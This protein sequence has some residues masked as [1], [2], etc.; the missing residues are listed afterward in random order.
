MAIT[1]QTI[2]RRLGDFSDLVFEVDL[3]GYGKTFGDISEVEFMVKDKPTDDND[4]WFYKTLGNAE[5]TLN[6][7]LINVKW[8]YNEYTYLTIGKEYECGLFI[9]FTG[10]PVADQHVSQTFR[11]KIVNGLYKVDIPAP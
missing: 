11:L 7:P 10:D 1:K 4:Q 6:D 2:E 5:I 8:A 9:T 3:S